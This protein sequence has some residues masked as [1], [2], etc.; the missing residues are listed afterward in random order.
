V[1]L[2]RPHLQQEVQFLQSLEEE[3]DAMIS[4]VIAN[5]VFVQ[6]GTG[7]ALLLRLI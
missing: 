5:Q 4:Q 2:V 3:L 7:G 6:R 1:R